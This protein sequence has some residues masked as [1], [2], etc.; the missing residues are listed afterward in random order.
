[1]A[2]KRRKPWRSRQGGACVEEGGL[3][4][5]GLWFVCLGWTRA[6]GGGTGRELTPRLLGRDVVVGRGSGLLLAV[7]VEGCYAADE[8]TSVVL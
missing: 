6:A 5:R 7:V 1:M 3:E 2:W 4:S 8:T